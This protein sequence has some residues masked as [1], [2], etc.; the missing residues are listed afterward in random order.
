MVRRRLTSRGSAP[1]PVSES[2]GPS[3]PGAFGAP[4]ASRL[5]QG[6]AAPGGIL[7]IGGPKSQKGVN[8][9]KIDLVARNLEVTDD[10]RDYVEK[11]LGKIEKYFDKG[12]PAQVVLS[13]ERGRQIVEITMPLGGMVVRGQE[14]TNDIYAAVNL[15]V[16]KIER[17]LEKYRARFQRRKREGRARARSVAVRETPAPAEENGEARVVKVKRFNMKPMTVDEAILQMNLLGHDFF[18]FTSSE[19]EQVNVLYRRKDGD[20]GLIEPE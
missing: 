15:A 6:L 11:K 14:A 4:G 18:V 2:T 16:E 7:V 13:S 17:R 10:L 1:V 8:R 3:A 9:L 5:L 12:V 19:T 20:Y